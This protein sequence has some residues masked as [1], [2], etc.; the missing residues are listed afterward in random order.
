MADNAT[1]CINGELIT[2]DLV[3]SSPNEEYAGLVGTVLS[4]EKLGTAEH[5]SGNTT[6][7]VHVNFNHPDYSEDR[8]GEIAEMVSDLYDR[9]MFFDECPIDD[10]IMAPDTLIRIT[11]ITRAELAKILDSGEKAEAYCKR[12]IE[13]VYPILM[14]DFAVSETPAQAALH[15]PDM[16]ND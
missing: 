16:F 3:I 12:V 1:I 2:G 8:M 9:Q 11:G 14:Q 13:E 7:D 6:D 15:E 4:V 10:V 5:E